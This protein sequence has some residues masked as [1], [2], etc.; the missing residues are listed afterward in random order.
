MA[1]K[2]KGI[3]LE[4]GGDSSGFTKAIDEADAASRSLGKEL[5]E[6][7]KGLKFDPNN[8]EL[9]GQKVEVTSQR[10]EEAQ[11]KLKA[12]KDVQKDVEEAFKRGDIGAE[13]YRAFCREVE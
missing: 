12:L 7:N 10:V 4:I 8:V 9:L 3:T 11:K 13:E 5:S 2:V 6:I 1:N